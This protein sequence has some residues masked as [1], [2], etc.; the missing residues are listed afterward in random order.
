MVE[1]SRKIKKYRLF[2]EI[3]SF[4]EKDRRIAMM[5][6]AV[7]GKTEQGLRHILFRFFPRELLKE[8][9]F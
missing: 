2:C 8:K 7:I 6:M 5:T 1:Y 3:L 9:K 4:S